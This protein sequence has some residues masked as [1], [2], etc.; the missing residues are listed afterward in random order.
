MERRALRFSS[1]ADIRA[2]LQELHSRGYTKT[3]KWDLSQVAEHLTDWMVFPMDGFPQMPFMIK[4]LIGTMRVTR[5]KLLYKKFVENQRMPI[6][7]PT[8]PQTV[9]SPTTVPDGDL[10][11]AERLAKQIDRLEG[12]RGPIHPSP[13]FGALTYEELV[14]LQLAHCAHHFNFL[15]PKEKN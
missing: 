14:A 5:G 8:M 12:F 15:V 6:G 4:L 13:L 7:Q 3:G 10:R 1:L 11:S 9:H 2:D